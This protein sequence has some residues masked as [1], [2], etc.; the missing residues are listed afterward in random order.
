MLINALVSAQFLAPI[1]AIGEATAEVVPILGASIAESTQAFTEAFQQE[2]AEGAYQAW[3]KIQQ[4]LDGLPQGKR[5]AIETKAGLGLRRFA[6]VEAFRGTF[7]SGLLVKQRSHAETHNGQFDFSTLTK[8]TV[9]LM[10]DEEKIAISEQFLDAVEAISFQVLD[11]I[12]QLQ[13]D[14]IA[15]LKKINEYYQKQKTRMI[16]LKPI[17]SSETSAVDKQWSSYLFSSGEQVS[18]AVAN[19]LA[20]LIMAF[21]HP[22]KSFGQPEE[23]YARTQKVVIQ[24]ILG[25]NGYVVSPARRELA[26]NVMNWIERNFPRRDWDEGKLVVR[27]NTGLVWNGQ[28]SGFEPTLWPPDPDNDIVFKRYLK[29][30]GWKMEVPHNPIEESGEEIVAII[31]FGGNT[32]TE[33]AG[34]GPLRTRHGWF[35]LSALTPEDVAKLN[36]QEQIKLAKQLFD[37]IYDL[38]EVNRINLKDLPEND[39]QGL[40]RIIKAFKQELNRLHTLFPQP[41]DKQL[42]LLMR[43]LY[44]SSK[45]LPTV[46]LMEMENTREDIKRGQRKWGESM[47]LI[48]FPTAFSVMQLADDSYHVR[49]DKQQLAN[50]ALEVARSY[51]L[52]DGKWEYI[53]SRYWTLKL[54]SEQWGKIDKDPMLMTMLSVLGWTVEYEIL[55]DHILMRIEFFI[56]EPPPPG[57]P[58]EKIPPEVSE[59][60]LSA[61]AFRAASGNI[62]ARIRLS[63]IAVG[64]SVMSAIAKRLIDSLDQG[65][66]ISPA[67][68]LFPTFESFRDGFNNF[69][70]F[71]TEYPANI[72]QPNFKRQS[73]VFQRFQKENP[74]LESQLTRFCTQQ[75]FG[76]PEETLFNP[77]KLEPILL[78]L[79]RAYQIMASYEDLLP[80]D[81]PRYLMQ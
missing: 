8:E 36:T 55:A 76:N 54:S 80:K 40:E 49:F 10:T 48:P 60:E 62:D 32:Y 56:P 53:P 64:K 81:N 58:A 6:N 24:P 69:Y 47:D 51:A 12:D 68:S 23:E 77:D 52:E 5:D 2:D 72:E 73:A 39:L 78:D 7:Y 74:E 16:S 46:I 67:A 50:H 59:K 37:A 25:E 33:S 1:Q 44:N 34:L 57:L 19:K 26:R 21:E 9:A 45:Q 65:K 11:A 20:M 30:L 35:E 38:C 66:L 63:D 27:N 79:Y 22:E 71:F 18:T 14:D 17:F 29:I 41:E 43:A 31:V 70:F 75:L 28:R 42:T 61:L 4:T 15:G 3:T 13:E